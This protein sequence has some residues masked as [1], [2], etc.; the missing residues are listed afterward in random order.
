MKLH[1]PFGV[2]HQSFITIVTP[3]TA[4]LQV[5]LKGGGGSIIK[6]QGNNVLIVTIGC[7]V[8]TRDLYPIGIFCNVGQA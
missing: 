4:H 2:M 5:G 3:P 6:V 8:T 7:G 1:I